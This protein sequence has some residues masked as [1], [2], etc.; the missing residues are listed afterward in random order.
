MQRRPIKKT[1]EHA[2]TT[3]SY[4]HTKKTNIHAK[5]PYKGDLRACAAQRAFQTCKRDQHTSKK[6]NIHAKEPNKKDLP[7]FADVCCINDAPTSSASI[8][9]CVCGGGGV[10]GGGGG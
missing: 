6:T 2:Q 10:S 3:E 1:H 7:A 9:W 5:E 4:R 8:D